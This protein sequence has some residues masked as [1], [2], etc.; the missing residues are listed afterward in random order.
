MGN[1]ETLH[2]TFHLAYVH[3]NLPT[4]EKCVCN[5]L[6]YLLYYAKLILMFLE[7][8]PSYQLPFLSYQLCLPRN[9][10]I[11]QLSIKANARCKSKIEKFKK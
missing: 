1:L 8:I 7:Q 10:F 11:Y 5:C 6:Q 4:I 3:R 2:E 9:P